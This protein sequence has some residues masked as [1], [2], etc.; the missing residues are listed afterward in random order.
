MSDSPCHFTGQVRMLIITKCVKGVKGSAA[1]ISSNGAVYLVPVSAYIYARVRC[2]LKASRLAGT[3]SCPITCPGPKRNGQFKSV[4]R[5]CWKHPL[6]KIRRNASAYFCHVWLS[7]G[8]MAFDDEVIEVRCVWNVRS[9]LHRSEK[10]SLGI[11]KVS[12]KKK[13]CIE[14]LITQ[15]HKIT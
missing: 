13:T 6:D 4:R 3:S 9:V 7:V 1:N 14:T 5:L 12:Y 11:F 10:S 2:P 15:Y 8:P